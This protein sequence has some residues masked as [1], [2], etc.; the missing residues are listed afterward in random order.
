[1]PKKLQQRLFQGERPWLP[2]SVAAVLI[3]MTGIWL[4][5]RHPWRVFADPQSPNSV[6]PPEFAQFYA[7]AMAAKSGLDPWSLEQFAGTFYRYSPGW[8]GIVTGGPNSVAQGWVAFSTA[9]IVALVIALGSGVRYRSWKTVA[10]LLAAAL[11]SWRGLSE[12]VESG[13][14][15][16]ILLGAT[17]FAGVILRHLP[18]V[19]GMLVGSLPWIRVPWILMLFPFVLALMSSEWDFYGRRAKPTRVFL[20]GA[21]V[22]SF[23][24]GAAIPSVVF[25]NERARDLI[26]SW[27][28]TLASTTSEFFVS[29]ANQSAWASFARW[30]GADSM[31]SLAAV[32][33]WG[34]FVLGVMLSR[35]IRAIAWSWLTPWLLLTELLSPVSWRWG[36]LF[37]VGV[38][39][40]LLTPRKDRWIQ[41][42]GVRLALWVSIALCWVLQFS[43]VN[44]WIGGG[45][46]TEFH[47]MGI[48]TVYWMSLLLV[49]L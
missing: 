27:F 45:S 10:A 6:V 8:M 29:P 5:M 48:V 38:P 39:F 33:I 26:F 1:M 20:T 23:V 12:S 41:A 43:V 4:F 11:L 34:G 28:S 17:V 30:S 35:P 32:L 13:T 31:L 16:L 2:A 3:A 36:S 9:G 44:R 40:A 22:A 19:S 37:A 42:R 25:G 47:D 18:F 24:W 7:Q 15:D 14:V 49:I 46:W 21:L